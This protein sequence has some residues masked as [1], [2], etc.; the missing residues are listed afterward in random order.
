MDYITQNR[1]I[2]GEAYPV[3]NA[4]ASDLLD[5]VFRNLNLSEDNRAR[6]LFYY[7]LSQRPEIS[8]NGMFFTERLWEQ[9]QDDEQLEAALS[10]IDNIPSPCLAGKELLADNADMRTYLS[11]HIHLLA[12]AKLNQK[13]G[14]TKVVTDFSP[15]VTFFC[16]D[17]S[18]IYQPQPDKD[19]VVDVSLQDQC[20]QC[21]RPLSEHRQRVCALQPKAQS[22]SKAQNQLRG[23]MT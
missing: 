9:A 8:E 10:F 20:P 2:E 7:R 5:A 12:E 14:K 16:P 6:A 1:R 23:L 19:G 13:T 15:S 18:G 3:G 17:G 4:T 11:E 22:Q 21:A